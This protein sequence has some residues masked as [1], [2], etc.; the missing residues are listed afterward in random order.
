[1][2]IAIANNKGGVGKS[3]IAVHLA[4][5]L[6]KRGYRVTLA[7]CD[8]QQSS[9]T[10]LREAVPEI[11]TIRLNDPNEIMEELPRLDQAADF[12]IGDG[13]GSDNESSRSLRLSPSDAGIAPFSRGSRRA[14]AGR[15]RPEHGRKELSAHRR[16]AQG[17]RGALATDRPHGIDSSADLRRCPRSGQHRL[18]HGIEG[19]GRGT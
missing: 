9:S 13:P 15:N 5:W 19:K 6:H 1:M 16:Y 10:W 17:S 11:Q 14:A 2:I 3:T 4:A 7:D 8:R 12:V 18:E